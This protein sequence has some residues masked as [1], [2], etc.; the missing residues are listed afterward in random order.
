[1]QRWIQVKHQHGRSLYLQHWYLWF[2]FGKT[3]GKLESQ[4][5]KDLKSCFRGMTAVVQS[6]RGLG[7]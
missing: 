3:N 7:I 5:V 2:K 1:M 6:A 4:L